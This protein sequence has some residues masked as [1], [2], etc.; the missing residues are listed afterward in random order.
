[1]IATRRFYRSRHNKVLAGVATG[2]GQYFNVDPVLFRIAFVLLALA[3]GPISIAGYILLA[4]VMP[5]RPEG[6]PEPVIT[7]SVAIGNGREI[8]G[9]VLLGIGLLTLAANMGLF[10]FI[11]WDLFWPLVMVAAGIALIVN[12]IR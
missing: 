3:A 6:E 2:L 9:I 11:R 12:R 4:I 5:E 7:S 10:A 8:A 1:M